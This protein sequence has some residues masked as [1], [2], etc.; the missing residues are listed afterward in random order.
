M[1]LVE[2]GRCDVIAIILSAWLLGSVLVVVGIAF[3][4]VAIVQPEREQARE[5]ARD[6]RAENERLLLD[7][8]NERRD[9]FQP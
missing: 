5:Q 9:T 6:L 4:W 3:A 2:E 8:A 1:R 7:L